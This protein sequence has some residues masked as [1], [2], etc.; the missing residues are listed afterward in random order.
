MPSVHGKKPGR[1]IT[2]DILATVVAEA[3]AQSHTPVNILGGFKK[4]G[5]HPFNPGEVS[6]RQ[7]AP[8][9]ALVEPSCQPLAFSPEQISLLEKRYAEGYD[10]LDQT[11][12]AW[13]SA[14]YSSPESVVCCS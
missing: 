7:V 4:S 14:N 6:D 1:V 12:L 2:E 9:K 3:F 13:K 11:Y 8:S 5:I 10:V